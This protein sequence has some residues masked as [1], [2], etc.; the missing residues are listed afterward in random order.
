[1][2][3]ARSSEDGGKT[4]DRLGWASGSS[5]TSGR[6]RLAEEASQRLRLEQL[7]GYAPD[8]NPDEGVWNYLKYVEMENLYC[9]DIEHLK[10]ELRRAKEHLRHETQIIQS[11]FGNGVV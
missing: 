11:F 6:G 7:P 10:T 5:G 1:M 4:D 9:R 8:L 3:P 2:R